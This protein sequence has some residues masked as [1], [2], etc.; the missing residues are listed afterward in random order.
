[1]NLFQLQRFHWYSFLLNS[2][3]ILVTKSNK[4]RHTK[5]FIIFDFFL[6]PSTTFL[7]FY[8]AIY[9]SFN[10]VIVSSN[11][12]RFVIWFYERNITNAFFKCFDNPIEFNHSCVLD[13]DESELDII[14]WVWCFHRD[15][16]RLPLQRK[17]NFSRNHSLRNFFLIFLKCIKVMVECD[18][19]RFFEW[20]S[21]VL[22]GLTDIM[23][24]AMWKKLRS[25]CFEGK[26][27]Y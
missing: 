4:I 15:S 5:F 16:S 14:I 25:H 27:S 22:L 19:G 20:C 9:F 1:M 3:E 18:V 13:S 24:C 26:V 17:I 12:V 7:I 2:P 8:S 21:W 6:F 11:F 10:N 23:I